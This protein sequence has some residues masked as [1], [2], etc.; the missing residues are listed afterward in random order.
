MDILVT[1]ATAGVTSGVVSALLSWYIKSRERGEQRRWEIKREACLEA[2]QIID[3]RFADYAWQSGS[4]PVKVD[5]QEPIETERIRSCFNRLI[6]SCDDE[7]VPVA[8][9]KCLNLKIGNADLEPLKMGSVVDFRNAIRKELGF[10]RGIS[11][12]VAWI[13]YIK[14]KKEGD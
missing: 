11:T 9:E 3:A 12:K 5:P 2:L 8:F 4:G 13:T 14:W 6:L 1:I 7:A 10:G